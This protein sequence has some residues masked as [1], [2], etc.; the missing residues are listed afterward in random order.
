MHRRAHGFGM[1]SQPPFR[2]SIEKQCSHVHL[3]Y[4][5][6]RR[7]SSANVRCTDEFPSVAPSSPLHQ[8]RVCSVADPLS[9]ASLPGRGFD[10]PGNES[11]VEDDREMRSAAYA[12]SPAAPTATAPTALFILS[13]SGRY[14]LRIARGR[15]AP[16]MSN[17][18]VFAGFGGEE[19]PHVPRS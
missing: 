16:G 14:H 7:K 5:F 11:H 3:L 13:V 12:T 17:N 18:A 6:R 10:R 8:H 9:R 4:I 2:D 19:L 15:R 1:P